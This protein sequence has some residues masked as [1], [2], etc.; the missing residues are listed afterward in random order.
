M[1]SGPWWNVAS[2]GSR[3]TPNTPTPMAW[4]GMEDGEAESRSHTELEKMREEIAAEKPHAGQRLYMTTYECGE[5]QYIR[6][7]K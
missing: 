1:E 2:I 7:Q 6:T 3:P 4:R 5:R